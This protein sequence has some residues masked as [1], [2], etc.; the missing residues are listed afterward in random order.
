MNNG[1]IQNA[2]IVFPQGVRL[3]DLRLRNGLIAEFG[4][5]LIPEAGEQVLAARGRYVIPG[6][7]DLH[8]HGAMGFDFSLGKYDEARA[9]FSQ[10][11]E[12]YWQ[13]LE[14]ALQFYRRKGVSKLYLTTVAAPI[15][16]LE[17]SFRLLD[18]FLY[19]HPVYQSLVAGINVEGTFI[20]S[21][22]FA[23]AQN[24][25]Y[26]YPAEPATFDRLQS[27]SGN[28]IRI[29][30]VP[31][32]HGEPGLELIR[33]LRARNIIV[34][35]GHS[36]AFA[37][38]FERAVDAGLSLAVHFLNGPSR[39]SSKSFHNGGAIE[40]IL[41]NDAV[42]VELIVDG[43][44]V[45][46]QYVRDV[47]V[48][49]GMDSCIGITDSIFVNGLSKIKDFSLAGLKGRVSDNRAYL[50][51]AGKANSL[52]GSVL[53][54]DRGF[55]N[56][57]N[58]LT[59]KGEGVWYRQHE[60]YSLEEALVYAVQIMCDNPAKKMEIDGREGRAGAGRIRIGNSA[61]LNWVHLKGEAGKYQCELEPIQLQLE[62][63]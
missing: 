43:Y 42:S 28:R 20:K 2:R 26:F 17:R 54:S 9:T 13:A 21:P 59:K 32:E 37:H 35:G 16:A 23:G 47:F 22:A 11:A 40:T 62:Q 57:I 30:N 36:A 29:V 8:N 49:K 34:A 46:P 12:A 63:T 55:N 48:R 19:R 3:G 33:Y 61:D 31:P 38:E 56:L 52:F 7:V 5:Q 39:S 50:E 45:H 18:E 6:F 10:N 24:P 25:E 15:T 41:R 44:H 27:A 53:S 60:A 51:A 1:L 14:K 4:E 58:W